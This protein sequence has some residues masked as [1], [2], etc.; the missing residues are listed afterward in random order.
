MPGYNRRVEAQTAIT[1]PR[2]LAVRGIPFRSGAPF[3]PLPPS[4][5]RA[6]CELQRAA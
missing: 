2:I 6:P 5:P 3:W 1:N 4:R